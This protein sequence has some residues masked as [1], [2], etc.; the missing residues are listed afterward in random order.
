M[1]RH[2]A[3]ADRRRDRRV[4]GGGLVRATRD[5]R[6][7]GD[8]AERRR[9]RRRFAGERTPAEG[10][11]DGR[12]ILWVNRLDPQKGFGV[13]VSAFERLA[14]ELDDVSLVVAGD[15]RDRTAIDLLSPAARRRRRACSAT[16]PHDALPGYHAACRRLR[17]A[18]ARSGELRDRP[19]RGDGGR[20]TGRGD[21]HPRLPGGRPRRGRGPARTPER[22]ARARG[23]RLEGPRP[24]ATSR[25][26]SPKRGARAPRPSL[27][28][29]SRPSS[30]PSTTGRSTGAR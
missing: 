26:R 3:P 16:V 10:L 30:R 20:R 22:P 27:G 21:G 28:T 12:R 1:L 19:R 9:R 11:P 25:R 29:W 6:P 13:M 24:T 14:A 5:P 17:L 18:G 2:G 23:R 8:R 4:R 7:G 15:G